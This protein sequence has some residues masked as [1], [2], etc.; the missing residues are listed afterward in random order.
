MTPAEKLHLE[1]CMEVLEAEDRL[2]AGDVPGEV[3]PLL[4][5]CRTLCGNEDDAQTLMS[6]IL[7]ARQRVQR[8]Q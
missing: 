1:G 2:K 4:D 3:G 8:G 6:N 5:F 7:A